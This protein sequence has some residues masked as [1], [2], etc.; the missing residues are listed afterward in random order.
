MDNNAYCETVGCKG[1][2]K[3]DGTDIYCPGTDEGAYT[4]GKELCTPIQCN[5]GEARMACTSEVDTYCSN[6]ICTGYDPTS[7]TGVYCGGSPDV[8]YSDE[9][10]TPCTDQTCL[11]GNIRLACTGSSDTRCSPDDC[12][13][14]DS[15]D[16]ESSTYC[17]EVTEP[18]K[19]TT[20]TSK[21]EPK[22]C[23]AGNV[24]VACTATT[25]TTTTRQGC[26][27]YTGG[28][29]ST[30]CVGSPAGYTKTEPQ[31]CTPTQCEAGKVRSQ[32]TETTDTTCI[33]GDCND[34]VN[35]GDKYCP[36]TD[37]GLVSTTSGL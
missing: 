25:N 18:G 35:H 8:G 23:L 16:P 31:S 9:E 22:E 33:E 13:G 3:G 24:R 6:N 28:T 7:D 19:S 11:A 5:P 15:N 27:G 12:T 1:Y 26:N 36:Q 29:D 32:C 37:T 4:V 34:R 17:L 14:Y 2:D 30:F 10:E 20:Q 21:C